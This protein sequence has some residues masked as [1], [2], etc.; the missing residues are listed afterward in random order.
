MVYMA[1]ELI[2]KIKL[3]FYAINLNRKN[4]IKD[5]ILE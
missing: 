3:Q 2:N 5:F 4:K 1:L